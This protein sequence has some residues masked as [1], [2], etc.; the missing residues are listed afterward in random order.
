M[1]LPILYSFR[2]CPY[3][4]RARLGIL[5]AGLRVELREVILRDKPLEFL[6]TSPTGTVPCLRHEGG[7]IDES[8]DIM[9]WAL[10]QNDPEGWLDMPAQGHE[11]IGQ[12]DGPFKQSLDRYKYATR[13]PDID[14]L[15]ERENASKYLIVY[16]KILSDSA[17]IFGEKPTLAD[18]ATLPFVRQFAHVD[19]TWFQAQPWPHLSRWLETFK[20]SDRFR[21]IMPKFA[22][23]HAEDEP[24]HFP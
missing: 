7:I 20:S 18:M 8:L 22:Q 17:F 23:W 11:I 14:P 1:T 6:Q 10:A 13:H 5:S 21:R 16:D 12:N 15:A 2:R 19:L 9:K 4:M 3:A 24:I